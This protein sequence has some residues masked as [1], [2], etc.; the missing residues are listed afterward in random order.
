MRPVSQ[1]TTRFNDEAATKRTTPT[2]SKP[3][4]KRR[5]RAANRFN[6]GWPGERIAFH[7]P[8]GT[9]FEHA[10]RARRI[11]ETGWPKWSV[12]GKTPKSPNHPKH[13][14]LPALVHTH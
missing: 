10:D 12:N 11:V 7:P 13:F 4:A 2:T 5:S 6:Q 14:S 8:V 1:M 3:G 9:H